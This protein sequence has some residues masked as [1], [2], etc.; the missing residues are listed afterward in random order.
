[1]ADSASNFYHQAKLALRLNQP[2]WQTSSA[3]CWLLQIAVAAAA[4]RHCLVLLTGCSCR[5]RE[6]QRR[7]HFKHWLVQW[8]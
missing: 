6:V 3:C 7:E 2:H 4:F 5:E 8:E 1:M